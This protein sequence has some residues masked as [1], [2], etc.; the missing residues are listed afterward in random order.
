MLLAP[1]H[2]GAPAPFA[3]LAAAAAVT[4]RV[5]LGTYVL[6]VPFWNPALL[7]REIATVDRI[8][9]GRGDGGPEPHPVQRPRPPLLLGGTGD[10]LLRLAARHADI[11]GYSAIFQRKGE[12]PGAFR[13]ATP[14][15]VEERVAF[16]RSQAGARLPEIECGVLV[17]LIKLTSDRRGR[18]EEL[19]TEY[20]MGGSEL[21]LDTPAV[22]LGTA[23]QIADQVLEFRERFGISYF[24]THQHNADA[25]AQV[26][27]LLRKG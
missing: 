18:A 25:L 2:L 7:A 3:M 8:S 4:E 11:V 9:G 1:D 12:A 17:Q 22:L 27:P 5:R 16:F 13:L 20:S 15:E 21:L 19:S 23:E 24:A 26:I 14:S 10:R 6:N